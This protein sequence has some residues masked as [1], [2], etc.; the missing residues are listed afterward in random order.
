MKIGIASDHRGYSKKQKLIEYLKKNNYDVID[1]GTNSQKQVDYPL[2]AFKLCENIEKIDRGIL[3]CGTGI[4]MSIAAN[5][6]KNIRCAKVNSKEEAKLTRQHNNANIIA[7][8]SKLSVFKMKKL[9][10]IF[11]E[12]D[13]SNLTK[14]IERNKMVDEYVAKL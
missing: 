3:I 8:S 6:V 10:K 11:I 4:G 2:Y 7:L 9:V 13:F 14:H 1:Y 5:K 12:T